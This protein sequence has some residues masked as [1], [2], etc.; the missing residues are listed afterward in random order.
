MVYVRVC[1]AIRRQPL[2]EVIISIIITFVR[3]A[4]DMAVT[5]AKGSYSVKPEY[6]LEV[7][8]LFIIT[9]DW[10]NVGG[11]AE[12]VRTREACSN[13]S[14]AKWTNLRPEATIPNEVKE[15]WLSGRRH[16]TRNAASG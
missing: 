16:R 5:V 13:L 4:L 11:V 12:W 3:T 10:R 6:I 8:L 2:S 14:G 15:G 7:C 9:L 1:Y